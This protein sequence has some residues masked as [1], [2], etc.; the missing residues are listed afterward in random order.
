MAK[1][2]QHFL[3]FSILSRFCFLRQTCLPHMNQH[4]WPA[5]KANVLRIILQCNQLPSADQCTY[6]QSS[7]SYSAQCTDSPSTEFTTKSLYQ[8]Q[9]HDMF[10]TCGFRLRFRDFCKPVDDETAIEGKY[11]SRSS[12]STIQVLLWNH[13]FKTGTLFY[14]G[15]LLSNKLIN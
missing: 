14:F 4:A 1:I 10:S 2:L 6:I 11:M 9:L 13:H 8:D 15:I 12:W 3:R 5:T 7:S